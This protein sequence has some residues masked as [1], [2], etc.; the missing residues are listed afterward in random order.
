MASEITY[1]EVKFKNELPAPVVKGKEWMGYLGGKGAGGSRAEEEGMKFFPSV[2]LVPTWSWWIGE[3][4]E[5]ND[6]ETGGVL[7]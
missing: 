2:T 7:K 1:A 6:Q 3:K 5:L 4:K